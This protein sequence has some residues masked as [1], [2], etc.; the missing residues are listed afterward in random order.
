MSKSFAKLADYLLDSYIEASFMTATELA[1]EL[2]LDAATVVRFSQNLGYQGFPEL[3]RE[4]RDHVKQDLLVRPVEAKNPES[5]AGV[6]S[7]A[8]QELNQA[9][10][11]T[12]MTLDSEAVEELVERIANT[13]RVIILASGP[14]QPAAYNLVH[15]LEQGEFPVYIAR[16]GVNALARTV[17]TTNDKDFLL[18]IDVDNE[19]PYIAPALRE[20]R[21]RGTTTAAIVSSPSLPSARSAEIVLAARS[22]QSL[23]ISIASVEAIVYAIIESLQWRYEDR[24]EGSDQ[25]IKSLSEKI[26]LNEG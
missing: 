23:G 14:A 3:Q 11:Q 25:A 6:V 1:H 20:A 24:F 9:I 15:F 16:A 10:E 22:N 17:H 2:N 19:A 18:A 13:R 12:S 21:S 26:Q 5:V 4:V 7:T 8:M